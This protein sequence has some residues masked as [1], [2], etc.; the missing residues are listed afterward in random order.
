MFRGCHKCCWV[1]KCVKKLFYESVWS[2]LMTI[3][4]CC[5]S[6]SFLFSS[7]SHFQIKNL[8]FFTWLRRIQRRKRF[9]N[10]HKNLCKHCSENPCFFSS[11]KTKAKS[12]FNWKIKKEKIEML[13][14]FFFTKSNS[15][16]ENWWKIVLNISARPG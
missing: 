2:N 7:L 11:T 15:S 6:C 12:F 10:L 9:F 14:Q 8:P 5:R 1:A 16:A 13:R 3:W 4:L